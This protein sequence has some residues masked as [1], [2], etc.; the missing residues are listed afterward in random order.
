MKNPSL[1]CL[2]IMHGLRGADWVTPKRKFNDL[3]AIR[4]S[5][6]GG[7]VKKNGLQVAMGVVERSVIEWFVVGATKAP[8][9]GGK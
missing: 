8:H 3:C 4:D 7:R 5:I 9:V 2:W 1:G 6:K